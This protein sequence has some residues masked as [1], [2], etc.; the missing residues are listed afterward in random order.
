MKHLLLV[1]L[2]GVAAG[3]LANFAWFGA[4][5]PARGDNLDA[6]LAWMQ[7]SLQLSPAQ[8][9][10]I[11]TLHEKSGPRL[12]ALAAQVGR[13][14]EEFAAFE[15]ERQTVGQI[16]FLEF[17]RF[18]EQRRNVD[19]ECAESTRRLILAASAVMN[20]QQRERYLALLDPAFKAAG[21]DTLN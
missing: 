3:L 2:A 19:R 18:V 16:D 7:E 4:H 8:F 13:M 15:R 11:K 20:P 9:A 17:A 14:R 1:V 10:R 6:Q 5:R 12:L 21:P